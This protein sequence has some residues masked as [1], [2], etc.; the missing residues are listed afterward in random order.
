MHF[1][2]EIIAASVLGVCASYACAQSYH[3]VA[4]PEGTAAG[5]S[6][7]GWVTGNFGSAGSP[8]AFI[9]H[10]GAFQ[11]LQTDNFVAHAV[12]NYGDVVGYGIGGKIN[13]ETYMAITLYGSDGDAG[14]YRSNAD[15]NSSGTGI[16]DA[17]DASGTAQHT[18]EGTEEALIYL[19]SPH[20]VIQLGQAKS[21]VLSGIN[22]SD[23]VVGTVL[24]ETS[25][26]AFIYAN[27]TFT[28]L[29]VTG[30]TST[31]GSALNDGGDVVGYG[32]SLKGSSQ[33][34]IYAGGVGKFIG[35]AAGEAPRRAL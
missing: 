14:V 5:M 30:A 22:N 17:T 34:F 4:V 19:N 12:N 15:L 20:I 28:Y 29:K 33:G 11:Q 18:N 24:G 21:K 2:R 27:R 13:Y 23:Q 9:Y 7:C 32:T 6:P 8:G 16:N 31:V 1:R 35:V 3:A 26:R 25:T 10:D